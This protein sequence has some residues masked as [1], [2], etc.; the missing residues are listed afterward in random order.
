MDE[1][2]FTKILNK[3]FKKIEVIRNCGPDEKELKEF[4]FISD[5]TKFRDNPDFVVS[6][7]IKNIN[8]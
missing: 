1:N 5:Y 4:K 7:P 3:N 6:E 8:D 2:I